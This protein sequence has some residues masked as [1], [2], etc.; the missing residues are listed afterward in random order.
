MPTDKINANNT[1]TLIVTLKKD[2]IIIESK[3]EKGI[4]RL[5]SKDDFFP[6]KA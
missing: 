6:I 2:K 1:T 3:N 5:T 4:E